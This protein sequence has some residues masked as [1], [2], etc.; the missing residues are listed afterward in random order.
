MQISGVTFL[1]GY[2]LLLGLGT[3]LQ[4]L[5]LKELTP[6]QLHFLISLGM[7]FTA[8]P[9][10]LFQQKSLAFPQKGILIGSSVGLLFALGS[11]TFTLALS[12]MPAGAATAI[13][14]S[15]VLVVTA[16][17]TVFLKEPITLT[18]VI[19]IVLTIIGVAIL[20]YKQG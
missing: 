11:F 8:I 15:Y 5:S 19:G 17:S 20:S 10:L 9:I 1:L 14:L 7:I 13:S 12:K 4:K 3:F 18:K 2:I 16:L 6:Y